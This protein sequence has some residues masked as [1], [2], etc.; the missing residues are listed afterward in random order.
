MLFGVDF[1]KPLAVL[2]FAIVVNTDESNLG[3]FVIISSAII[4]HS[5]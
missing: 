3:N 4:I 1:I 2:D 5:L